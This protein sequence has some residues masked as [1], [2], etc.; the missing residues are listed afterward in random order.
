MNDVGKILS[1]KKIW[2]KGLHTI[3]G[4]R[5]NDFNSSETVYFAYP[6]SDRWNR[7]LYS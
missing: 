2:N 1:H 6:I 7:I 3:A 4:I 5:N